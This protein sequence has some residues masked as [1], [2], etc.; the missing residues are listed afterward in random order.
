MMGENS[1]KSV[2]FLISVVALYFLTAVFRWDAVVQSLVFSYNIAL[3]VIPV[4]AAIFLIMAGFNYFISPQSVKK[5]IG[6]SSGIRRWVFAVAGGIIS[7]G[8]I[9]MWYPMLK[10]LKKHGVSYGFIAA[11]L[12]NR[13]VKIPL[14]PLIIVYFGLKYTIVLTAVMIAASL[15]QGI[16]FEALEGGEFI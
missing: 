14:L 11:F 7:T 16:I 1:H 9:Y 6:R 4:F 13:A 8:P 2:Y 3:N 10:D 15:A 5:H 12:Y